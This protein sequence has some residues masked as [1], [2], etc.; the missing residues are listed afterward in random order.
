MSYRF[1]IITCI[2]ILSV[3]VSL[4]IFSDGLSHIA[5]DPDYSSFSS[6]VSTTNG[7][8]FAEN[9]NGYGRIYN[10][11]F[12]GKVRDI[13]S[14][15]EVY[16]KQVDEILVDNGLIYGLFYT[17]MTDPEDSGLVPV[18]N[19][20][21]LSPNLNPLRQADDILIPGTEN[22]YDLTMDDDKFYITTI[23][24]ATC[25]EV[26]VYSVP[27]S[28]LVDV[29]STPVIDGVRQEKNISDMQEPEN[30]LFR[31]YEGSGAFAD[32]SYDDGVLSIRTDADEPKGVFR[33][34]VRVREAVNDISFTPLQLLELYGDYILYWG[35]GLLIWFILLF[36]VFRVTRKRNRVVY[37]A[38]LW[39]VILLIVIFGSVFMMKNNYESA[40]KNEASRF[41]VISMQGE[42][43]TIGNL[44]KVD[45]SAKDFYESK[46]YHSIYDSLKRFI[47]RKGFYFMFYDALIVRIKDHKVLVDARGMN[48]DSLDFYYGNSAASVLEDLKD[49]RKNYSFKDTTFMDVNILFAGIKESDLYN[50][51]Y[52]L[53]GV[54]WADDPFGGF[55]SRTRNVIIISVVL[56]IVSSLFILVILY[57]QNADLKHFESEIRAVALGKTDVRA[58]S[59]PA[60]D[61][62]AMW[63]SLSEIGKR[64]ENMNYDRF[65]IIE[66][67]YR[68]APK[69]I[70]T[71]M[72]KDS[73]F[74]VKNGDFTRARGS[75][76]L[77][78]TEHTGYGTKRIKALDNVVSY[79]DNY[80]GDK[81]GILV[82]HDSTLSLLQFL[83]LEGSFNTV[84]KAVQFIHR[85]DTDVESGKVSILM[86][87]TSFIYGV[88]GINDKCLTYL[89]SEDT[90]EM[91][92]YAHWFEK[93]R[94]PLVITE[95]IKNR[96]EP[97]NLRYIGYIS[98]G[99]GKKRTKLYEVLDACPARERQLKLSVKDS[100]EESINYFYNKDFYLARNSFTEL[101]K[102][103]PEDDITRWYLFECERYLSEEM[104]EDDFGELKI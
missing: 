40:A 86:Y 32:A 21:E 61:M 75:L 15:A 81:E 39:E 22:C 41:A 31:K 30:I 73:I 56:F 87:Y 65:R 24:V 29:S 97:E 58:P 20:V 98:T 64:I 90:K 28:N 1:R 51:D 49:N 17:Y 55:W 37:M 6:G 26:N 100:F 72:E 11:D 89:T 80:V 8:Y 66:A 18:Y 14:S 74:E 76:M 43:D 16:E 25:T 45:F 54:L 79:M 57:M 27:I 60:V 83:F 84:S 47:N 69:D 92:N 42:M 44:D 70:E 36:I 96:E 102:E 82:S 94:V 77:V 88:A 9:W 38:V 68:F 85:N 104:P 33:P 46:T 2:C 48:R 13:M 5:H 50:H 95:E 53:V 71:I 7:V 67:Y 19:I 10:M 101:L 35:G 62:Q 3:L 63:N 99:E 93:L 59:I 78:A 103:C 91:E 4:V 34:D 52:A 23:D 12:N